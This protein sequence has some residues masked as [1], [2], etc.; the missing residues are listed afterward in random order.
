MTKLRFSV[1]T[2]SLSVLLLATAMQAQNN[3]ANQSTAATGNSK[4]RIVRLSEVRGEVQI[5]HESDRGFESAMAN[6]PI[7]EQSRLRTGTGVAEVEFEDNST[8]RL[9][10]NSVV[11]F[12]Q[13]ERTATGKT[14]TSVHVIQGIAYVSLLKTAGNQFTLL[15]GERKLDLPP[16][17][18]IRLEIDGSDARL[19]VLDGAVNMDSPSGVVNVTKKRTATF[20]IMGE[21]QPT[22]VKDVASAELDSW[23]HDAAGYH[24]RVASSSMLNSPYAYGQND[25]NYYGAFT[26]AGGCGSMWRPYFASAAWNPYSN[27]SWAWYPGAGYS[28]VSPYPWG[29]TPFHYGSWS[30]CAGS[31]WG[32]MPGG[33]W[34]GLNNGGIVAPSS[35]G[36]AGI[37]PPGGPGV[38]PHPPVRAPR[39]GEPTHTA[40]NL[41]PLVQSG[42]SSPSSFAFRKDSAGLGVPR[43]LG[44]LDKLSRQADNR[45]I[46]ST[47]V[48]VNA[49]SATNGHTNNSETL[50]ASIHRGAPPQAG[51]QDPMQGG[52]PGGAGSMQGGGSYGRPSPGATQPSGNMG[53]SRPSPSPGAGS[54]GAR[55][56]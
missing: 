1:A 34:N 33:A 23:D 6:L 9:G 31:G 55:P 42:V 52:A 44:R 17:T 38:V 3:D 51:F 53:G 41:K 5:K 46:A 16:A 25:L 13:L 36:G 26:D 27:G 12:P 37:T 30:Y 40:V 32:W 39:L 47:P 29:W 10:P 28:W 8:L 11:E 35:G 54:S 49:P 2:A 56:H 21:S 50:G 18:H 24:S 22:V 45:G 7:V 48:Y 43:D 19:A 20:S 15:F 14:A 4:V